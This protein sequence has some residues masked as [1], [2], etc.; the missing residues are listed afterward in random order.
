MKWISPILW[1]LKSAQRITDD[2]WVYGNGNI[3]LNYKISF[4]Q[5]SCIIFDDDTSILV[6]Y[7]TKILVISKYH[8]ML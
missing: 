8:Q 6:I 7:N 3:C 2:Q 5:S 4:S 1:S